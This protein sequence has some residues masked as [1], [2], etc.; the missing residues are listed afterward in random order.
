MK[1]V[2]YIK[3]GEPKESGVFQRFV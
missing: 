3:I 2:V 1:C